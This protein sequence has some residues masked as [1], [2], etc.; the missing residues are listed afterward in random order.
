MACLRFFGVAF[1]LHAG[2]FQEAPR[3]L[4]AVVATTERFELRSDSRVALHHFLIDWASAD[5]GEWPSYAPQIAERDGWRSGL[6]AEEQRAWSAAVQAYGAAVG[7][8]LL[9]DEGMLATRAWAAGAAPRAE[10]PAADQGLADAFAAALPIDV[11]VYANDVGAYSSAGRLSISSVP[12]VNQMPQAIEMVFHESSHMDGMEDPL[13][14]ALQRAFQAAGTPEPERLW[15]DVIFYTSGEITR[16]VLAAHGEA[17]YEHY[18]TLGL[19]R[20]GAR[21]TVQPPAFAEYWRPFL[22]S[23]SNDEAARD[24]ALRALAGALGRRPEPSRR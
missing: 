12:R 7:R 21:W 5:A 22:E 13:R 9:F 20:R 6:S 11:M 10:I 8:S 14:A 15:H 1:L 23:G 3:T 24:A 2:G 16:L 17:G 18:G 4:D 19:Y